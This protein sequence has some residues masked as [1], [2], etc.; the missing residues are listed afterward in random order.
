MLVNNL[1]I[2]SRGI[3]QESWNI[4]IF[5]CPLLKSTKMVAIGII[6]VYLRHISR[7]FVHL[8]GNQLPELISQYNWKHRR[9]Y[10]TVLFLIVI[11]RWKLFYEI[12][13]FSAF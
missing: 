6:S 7:D 9:Y 11:E 4:E 1:L 8:S 3:F 5:L 10:M 12:T 2:A 13:I